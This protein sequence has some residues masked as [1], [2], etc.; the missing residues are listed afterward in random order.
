MKRTIQTL[1][2]G[3]VMAVGLFAGAQS[4]QAAVFTVRSGDTL[5]K[6]F[7]TT[8]QNVCAINALSNC[9]LIYPGQQL[10]DGAGAATSRVAGVS[11]SQ[12]AQVSPNVPAGVPG[13]SAVLGARYVY[14]ANGPYSF[15]CSGL[16]QYLARQ[17]GIEIPRNS[18]GQAGYGRSI[19]RAELWP[20]D[21]VIMTGAS[22]VGMYIGNNQL[23]HALNPSQGV[24]IHNL[25]YAL[26][27]NPLH[28]FRAIGH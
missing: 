28:S 2:V 9:N 23:V 12:P 5:S 16:T 6:L 17:R 4:A 8:W 22:H 26:Q 7:P 18:Y 19:S 21:L 24:Q 14:G 1:I 11:T 10:D 3:A 15:D 20:G 25:D 27:Y 13:L